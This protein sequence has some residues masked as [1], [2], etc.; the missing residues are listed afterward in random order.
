ML[1][2]PPRGVSLVFSSDPK[3]RI[4]LASLISFCLALCVVGCLDKP[5]PDAG[6]PTNQGGIDGGDDDDSAD[7]DD[8]TD[9]DDSVNDS[10]GIDSWPLDQVGE[11][12]FSYYFDNPSA[13]YWD[14]VRIYAWNDTGDPPA[15]G[16]E[17]CD[18][19][20]RVVYALI[21]DTC[22]SWGYDGDEYILSVGLDLD[23]G[24][25]WLTHDQGNNWQVFPGKGSQTTVGDTQVFEAQH[26]WDK[27]DCV[28]I[29]GDDECD[30]GSELSYIEAFE[31][32]H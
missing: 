9:D 19:T 13:T 32:R 11:V 15:T 28:D 14:C 8:S 17:P 2:Q 25:L 31:L 30:P 1:D 16:C 27:G 23:N 5:A 18:L 20:W 26:L 29:D 10:D 24:R 3:Q 4:S 21:T 22:G 12:S 7:D 6:P